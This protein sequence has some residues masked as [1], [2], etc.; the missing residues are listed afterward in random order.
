MGLSGVTGIGRNVVQQQIVP[1]IQ[2]DD[3]RRGDKTPVDSTNVVPIGI[4][5]NMHAGNQASFPRNGYQAQVPQAPLA[6]IDPAYADVY[7]DMYARNDLGMSLR[8]RFL[9]LQLSNPG[10]YANLGNAQVLDPGNR[11]IPLTESR[12][13]FDL[14]F[15]KNFVIPIK[16]VVNDRMADDVSF[17]S[18]HLLAAM[19]RV[20]RM[21]PV[22]FQINSPGGSIVS[23]NSILEDMDRLKKAKVDG[24][25]IVVATICHGMAA[26][27]AS[28]IL[29]N[30]T[31][32]H[33][34]VGPLSDVMIHQPLGGYSGRAT[35]VDI[36]TKRIQ[37]M[38]KWINEFF[39]RT[40]R[41]K[42]EDLNKIMEEDTYYSAEEALERGLVDK[43]YDSYATERYEEVNLDDA[44]KG[45]GIDTTIE[46]PK[47]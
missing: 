34:Y 41:M 3:R 5:T 8:D 45:L 30:G 44:F 42:I 10:L 24:K 23:M 1:A 11:T 12:D 38:K 16:G 32:G 37:K 40:T 28:V 6:F 46:A 9:A 17:M 26:S 2:R 43:I 39:A 47:I 29:A 7:A 13:P 14:I 18:Q 21:R 35:Q 20:G 36:G 33:R 31:P 25:E 19:T 22:H 27:A 4:P 15:L